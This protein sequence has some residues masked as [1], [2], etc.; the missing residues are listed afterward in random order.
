LK[1]RGAAVIWCP[2]SNLSMLGRTVS[3]TVLHSGIPVA[4]ATDS[5]LSAQVDLLD[6]LQVARRFVPA[7]RLFDMVTSAPS[8]ILRLG[9]ADRGWIAVRSDSTNPLDALRSGTISLVFS[10]GRVRLISYELAQQLPAS[11]RRKFQP[12][13]IEGRPP[14]LVAAGVRALRRAATRHLG[15][16]LR[17]AGKRV[18]S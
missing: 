17:L 14:V 16:D 9:S 5:A 6:E 7:S 18:L 1:R 8:K 3:K 10:R 2:T 15:P 12:L 13:A 4:L 11:E